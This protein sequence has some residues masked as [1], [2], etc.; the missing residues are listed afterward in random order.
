MAS[1]G[2]ACKCSLT[3]KEPTNTWL[4][5]EGGLPFLGENPSIQAVP[6]SILNLQYHP[7][8]TQ[9]P[10]PNPQSSNVAH[11]LD[12]L[13]L[14]AI[15]RRLFCHRPLICEVDW[16]SN[17]NSISIWDSGSS[18]SFSALWL[19]PDL[20]LARACFCFHCCAC[21]LPRRPAS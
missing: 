19:G 4:P 17:S 3:T 15:K 14:T 5:L 21:A 7:I 2:S 12:K 1:N 11:A 9:P 10:I 20:D 16:G 6:P 8:P 13:Q 18:S